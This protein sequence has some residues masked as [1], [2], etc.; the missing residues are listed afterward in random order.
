MPLIKKS[1]PSRIVWVDSLGSQLV[2]P[3]IIGGNET[4]KPGINL[5]PWDDLKCGSIG[6]ILYAHGNAIG[7]DYQGL[8][9]NQSVLTRRSAHFLC[10]VALLEGS[11]ECCMWVC[12]KPSD[13]TVV[14]V[15]GH[16]AERILCNNIQCH[17][18]G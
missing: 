10:N 18:K 16:S 17:R 3:P 4:G 9:K 11:R 15:H 12:C 13:G 1:A 7:K 6:M 2:N 14:V 8:A 5:I